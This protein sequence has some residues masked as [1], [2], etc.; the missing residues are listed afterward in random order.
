MA[1]DPVSP[2]TAVIL[3]DI[4]VSA[5][6]I[7][8]ADKSWS[9]WTAH[10]PCPCCGSGGGFLRHGS[11]SK[12]HYR[13]RLQ[14][15]RL[16]CKACGS[17]HALIPEFSLPG[18]SLGTREVEQ[19]VSDRA[20]GVSRVDAGKVLRERGVAVEYLRRIERMIVTAL[21][22]AKALFAD[23]AAE[24]GDTASAT[25]RRYMD[26]GSPPRRKGVVRSRCGCGGAVQVAHA[27]RPAGA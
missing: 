12:Y 6:S 7:S 25:G 21:E 5:Y 9:A 14:L 10:I 3:I 24:K 15:L 20:N 16:R 23:L 22:R 8:V 27:D 4:S 2:P 1:P 17:T 18:T 13:Q 11:Y 19:F 26:S